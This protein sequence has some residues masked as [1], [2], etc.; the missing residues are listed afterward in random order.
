MIIRIV[1]LQI[2]PDQIEKA[3]ELLMEVAPKVRNFNGCH[4][5][6]LLFD[7]HKSGHVQTYSKWSAEKDLN[8]YRDSELFIKFWKSIK[9]LFER[10]AQAWSFEPGKVL[11]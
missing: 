5:L 7:I 10:P 6:E 9:P 1:D 11:V 8:S 3:K 2:H 4:Y